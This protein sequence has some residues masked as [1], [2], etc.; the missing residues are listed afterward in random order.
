[1]KKFKIITVALMVMFICFS[2]VACSFTPNDEPKG[3]SEKVELSQATLG[4][5]EFEN[6]DTVEIKQENDIVTVSGVITAMT[7]AEKT[8]FGIDDVTHAVTLKLT[9]DKEKTISSFE[10]AGDTIKVFSDNEN[11]QNYVGSLTDVL[12]NEENDDA[13]C[14]LILSANTKEYTMTAT[15]TDKTSSVIKLKIEATLATAV[16]E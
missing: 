11:D 1:M 6:A 12:D 3:V 8:A 16:S 7:D 9:F 13:F 4:S 14:Y 10:L 15:Y 2:A 5:V